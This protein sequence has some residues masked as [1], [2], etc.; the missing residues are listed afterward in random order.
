MVD[1]KKLRMMRSMTQTDLAKK[2]GVKSQL[3]SMIENGQREPTLRT[4]KLLAPHLGVKW[5]QF[6]DDKGA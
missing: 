5:T 1:V 2:S 3:I 4:A 6:F